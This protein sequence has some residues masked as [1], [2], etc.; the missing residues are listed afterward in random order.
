MAEDNR[1]DR[2]MFPDWFRV[3]KDCGFDN[4]PTLPFIM[5]AI[6]TPLGEAPPSRA[7]GQVE[8]HQLLTRMDA[9]AL[10]DG[11]GIF[12]E[13]CLKLHVYVAAKRRPAQ[14]SLD[15]QNSLKAHNVATL[16]AELWGMYGDFIERGEYSKNGTWHPFT[17]SE[18]ARIRK[19]LGI[20]S[21]TKKTQAAS[22]KRRQTD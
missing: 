15:W 3:I 14:V 18:K 2:R 6:R 8:L 5:G 16:T 21:A 7:E 9:E 4:G 11:Y 17:R 12:I 10:E 13:M 19:T 22:K 1:A 20:L